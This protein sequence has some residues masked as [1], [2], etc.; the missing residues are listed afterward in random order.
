[1]DLKEFI[2]NCG[3]SEVG[4]SDISAAKSGTL[5]EKYEGSVDMN[6]AITIAVKLSDA[7]LEGITDKP[8]HTYFHHYRTV[9]THLDNLMLKTGMEI[10]KMGYRYIPIAASQSI[11]GLQGLFQHKTAARLSGL[12]TVG[13]SGLFISKKFGTRVRLG[14]IITDMPLPVGTPCT[15]DLCGSCRACV[16]ACPAMAIENKSFDTEN[17]NDTLNR[18]MCSEY[19][20][21]HF[22]NIGR[23]AV[24]GICVKTCK[25]SFGVTVN[26]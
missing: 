12:G 11:N 5:L 2:L 1:M 23:G 16:M 3:G 19:M 13:K 25:Y 14:T 21:E 26:K 15:E 17:P 8:T 9:N 4:F 7:V 18:Q 24:C 6:Y 10:E 22:K 20:K